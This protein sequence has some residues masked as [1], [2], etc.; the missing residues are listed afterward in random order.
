M[1]DPQKTDV[2]A[3]Y[4]YTALSKAA[5]FDWSGYRNEDPAQILT[6]KTGL[7][8][9]RVEDLPPLVRSALVAKYPQRV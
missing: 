1:N 8:V 4:A 9:N 5:L 6:A 7:K 3:H 2:M